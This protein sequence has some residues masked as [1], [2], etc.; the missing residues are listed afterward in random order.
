MDWIYLNHDRKRWWTFVKTVTNIRV[1]QNGGI[2]WLCGEPLASHDNYVVYR[3]RVWHYE[4]IMF[5]LFTACFGQFIRP[6]SNNNY[7]KRIKTFTDSPCF[8]SN[9]VCCL[10]T[11]YDIDGK[12]LLY[13][14]R[15][16]VDP[17][18]VINIHGCILMFRIVL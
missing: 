18:Y 14:C 9:V 10:K 1:L 8:T 5:T 15:C 6:S 11:A 13:M 4:Y 7:K 17:A 2:S 16:L 3:V 12:V